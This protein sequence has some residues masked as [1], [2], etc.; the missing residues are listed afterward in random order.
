MPMTKKSAKSPKNKSKVSSLNRLESLLEETEQELEG[1]IP[2]IEKL[3]KQVEKLRQLRLEKQKLITLKLSLQSI[4]E[5]Y[6]DSK[7]TLE[8]DYTL[9][10]Y[11]PYGAGPSRALHSPMAGWQG[12]MGYEHPAFPAPRQQAGTFIPDMAFQQVNQVLRK[13]NSLNYELFRAIVFNGG[14]ASTEQIKQY[15]VEHQITQPAS[16]QGFEAVELTDISSRVNYL[17]RK[18]LV[19]PDGRG[20]FVSCLG[21]LVDGLSTPANAS[22]PENQQETRQETRAMASSPAEA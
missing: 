2:Q 8:A 19:N 17:V 7:M 12:T 13:R 18:G 11:L 21:W 14:Q 3:E 15:L 1:L 16:G 4:L 5:N 6:S 20:N 9:E 22:P 10:N